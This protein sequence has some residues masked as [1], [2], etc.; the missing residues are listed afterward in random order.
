MSA[1]RQ[2][3]LDAEARLLDHYGVAA[4]SRTVE[5]DDPAVRVRVLESGA[6][7]PLLLIHGSGMSAGTWAPLLPHLQGRRVLA[8][9]LPGFGA[10]GM[11]DYT[12]RPLR[13][14][15]VAQMRS[16]VDA[17]GLDRP[18]IAGTSLGGM[19]AMN[20]ALAHPDRVSSI[21]SLGVPAV[22]L[23]G[24]TGSG[25][26][27]AMTTPVLGAVLQRM[28]A[29]PSVRTVRRSL[30]RDFGPA[31]VERTPD[32]WFELV[33]CGM[34]QPGWGRSLR[35]HLR[36]GLRAGRQRPEAAFSDAELARLET[37]TV[38]VWGEDD[39]YGPPEIGRRAVELMPNARLETMPGRHAPFLD[40]PE[41]CAALI[42]QSPAPPA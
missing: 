9:D 26:F 28:P 11:Y 8:V 34:A 6:G 20:L 36:L 41:R 25:F 7:E 33:R 4:E 14:H 12:G 3:L 10:N 42:M 38:F 2:D 27:R 15:A 17:L 29:P 35:S 19:W 39:P 37:P 18:Q 5:L 30:A 13:E 1:G 31:A 21:T 32:E 16:F 40:D 22:A 24:M 23:R